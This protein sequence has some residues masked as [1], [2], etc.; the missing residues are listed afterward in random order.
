MA[1]REKVH[2]LVSIFYNRTGF[3]TFYINSTDGENFSKPSAVFVSLGMTTSL[4]QLKSV[5]S[6]I[7]SCD[8][9]SAKLVEISSRRLGGVFLNHVEKENPSQYQLTKNQD[10]LMDREKVKERIA[11]LEKKLSDSEIS[12]LAETGKQLS[13][14]NYLSRQLDESEGWSSHAIQEENGEFR[15]YHLLVNYKEDSGVEYRIGI[16][17]NETEP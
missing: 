2:N 8:G 16:L 10:T 3:K 9:Y 13:R 6:A 15:I 14:L 4:S 1:D 5:M 7:D 12:D 17:V 11:E